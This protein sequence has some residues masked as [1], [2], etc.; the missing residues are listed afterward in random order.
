M[1]LTLTPKLR[2]LILL[3][4]AVL[5]FGFTAV[6]GDLIDLSGAVIVW[7]RVLI[8]CI[9]LLFF[10]RMGKDLVGIPKHLWKSFAWIGVLIGIHWICFYGAIKL[11]NASITLVCMATTSFFTSIIEPLYLKTKI[12]KTE[13]TLG[14]L[15]VPCMYLVVSGI[16][17]DAYMG[18]VVGLLSAFFAAAFTVGNKK[19][20]DDMRPLVMSFAE[21][22]SVLVMTTILLPI[23][24]MVDPSMTIMPPTWLDWIY[25]LVLAL[26]CTTLAWVISLVALRHLSAFE[27]NLIVNLEPV[28]GILLAAALLNE[29]ESL[30][31]SFYL[32]TGLIL[33]V[34]LIYP[35]SKKI[36]KKSNAR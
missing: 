6:L 16:S 29:H 18:V 32:G 33:V 24:L 7:W 19:I 35:L 28:Y 5:L 23:L 14:A 26:V 9:S 17:T 31:P 22:S 15:M 27:N 20:V 21:L 25:L 3:H 30:S 12:S 13:I 4:I 34:V 11:S 1:K 10:L 36:K 2:A 8:T